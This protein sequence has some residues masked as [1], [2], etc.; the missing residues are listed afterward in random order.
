MLG[1]SDPVEFAMQ[2][3]EFQL[4]RGDAALH[5]RGWQARGSQLPSRDFAA[6]A[7]VR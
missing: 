3:S 5:R 7:T 4:F 2:P 6:Q 1:A